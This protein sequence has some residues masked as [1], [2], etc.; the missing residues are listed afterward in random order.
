MEIALAWLNSV[1]YT[2]LDK[3]CSQ[4]H[5]QHHHQE[6]DT[7]ERQTFA[8]CLYI[9]QTQAIFNDLT[10]AYGV[11]RVGW[12]FHLLALAVFPLFYR[13]FTPSKRNEFQTRK[14]TTEKK[15]LNFRRWN[16]DWQTDI[17]RGK[18]EEKERVKRRSDKN[19][20]FKCMH[21][22]CIR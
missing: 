11:R 9:L 6:Y 16:F 13:S 12:K 2:Y 7:N 21:A 18:E 15:Y 8:F 19:H 14:T 3:I 5:Q 17:A 4:Q 22:L 20:P 10:K 1:I